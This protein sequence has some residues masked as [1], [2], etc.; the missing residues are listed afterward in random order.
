MSGSTRTAL[1][2]D[3]TSAA[4]R[5][6]PSVLTNRMSDGTPPTAV[7]LSAGTKS[8]VLGEL[9]G[10]AWSVS[11]TTFVSLVRT[12][13]RGGTWLVESPPSIA[14]PAGTT[15][16]AL[17]PLVNRTVISGGGLE[18]KALSRSSSVT[19][20]FVS[21]TSKRRV[22]PSGIDSVGVNVSCCGV[23]P[24]LRSVRE[25]GLFGPGAVVT[26]KITISFGFSTNVT[27]L[28]EPV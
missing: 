7:K 23:P 2:I 17:V 16:A 19:S 10:A 8:F 1:S 18:R 20:M 5:N 9:L 3:G 14:T 4:T 22:V 21:M 27:A 25:T 28:P 15:W 13:M 24:K 12:A 11:V 6:P 26:S